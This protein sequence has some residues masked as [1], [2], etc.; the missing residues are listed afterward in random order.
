VLRCASSSSGTW[1][2]GLR[3]LPRDLRI[4][5]LTLRN[6]KGVRFFELDAKGANARI[7]GDNATGK[8]TLVDAFMWLLFD[9]DSANRKDFEIK[10]LGS[11]GQAI[12]GLEH[13]VKAVLSMGDRQIT[14]RKVYYEK[15]TKQRGSATKQFSG[16]TTDHY[17]DGVPVKQSEYVAA[18]KEIADETV[19]R[20]LTDPAYFSE[21]LHWQDRRKTLLQVC[22]DITDNDVIASS[23]QL[24]ELP[25]ILNGRKLDDHRAVILQRRAEINRE[26][27]RIPVR[28]DEAE[29]NMPKPSHFSRESLMKKLDTLRR[30]RSDKQAERV[31]LTSGGEVAEKTKQIALLE[32]DLAALDRR[33]DQA[34]DETVKDEKARLS[35]AEATVYDLERKAWQLERDVKVRLDTIKAREQD[36]EALRQRFF[37]ENGRELTFEQD[38]VCPTCGQPIPEERLEAARNEALARFN[39]E[40]AQRLTAIQQEGKA[41]RAALDAAR[42]EH[43]GLVEELAKVKEELETARQAV[44]TLCSQ[45]E[46]KLA[47][48]TQLCPELHAERQAKLEQ[49]DKLQAEIQALRT[50]AAAAVAAVD[51]EIRAFD[52]FISD[53]EHQLNQ[54]EL[55]DNLRT[56]IEELKQQERDLSAEYERLEKE[57]YLCDEFV[58]RKVALLDEHINSR[59]ELARFKMFE[60]HINGGISECCEVLHNG[61][62]YTTALNRGARI[63]VGLDIIRTLANHYGFHPPI[64][65]DNREAVTKIIPM[66]TQVISLVVSE[67][68]RELRVELESA[69]TAHARPVELLRK[70]AV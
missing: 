18:V 15:W 43:S 24:A 23:E 22:G 64:F 52:S 30:Q 17:V 26:L 4:L 34:V 20:L 28:I 41:A 46:A 9:K 56:R 2:K 40:K 61:V 5:K 70:E 51:E 13:E 57:L 8:T 31:R 1:R 14:L 67:K 69:A 58:R 19:F 49:K 16:H 6:F 60:Q 32:S 38:T 12:H 48:R 65:V 68:D 66:Q 63:N 59:F 29:R 35:Q 11:D 45:I 47:D 42:V 25:A 54:I 3:Q 53:L 39:E 27:E 50:D 7:Y 37:K 21:T 62:P 33:V 44:E 10:T 55:R 36:V